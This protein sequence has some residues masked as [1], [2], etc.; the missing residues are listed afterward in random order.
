MKI[1]SFINRVHEYGMNHIEI[2][3]I[4]TRDNSDRSKSIRIVKRIPHDY[5]IKAQRLMVEDSCHELVRELLSKLE[6]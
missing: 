1:E 5:P 4:V 3:I 2:N 6:E